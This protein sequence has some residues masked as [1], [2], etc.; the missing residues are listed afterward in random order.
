MVAPSARKR[1]R[2]RDT[3]ASAGG[4]DGYRT[5]CGYIVHLMI[6]AARRDFGRLA[7]RKDRTASL[8]AV[9]SPQNLVVG[10]CLSPLPPPHA[11]ES[12]QSPTDQRHRNGFRHVGDIELPGERALDEIGRASCRA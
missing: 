1:T 5:P 11:G 8:Q 3:L 12:D 7:Q 6:A 9:R 10:T 2:F 4:M